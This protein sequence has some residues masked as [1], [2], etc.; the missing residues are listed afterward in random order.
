MGSETVSTVTFAPSGLA[1]NR[2]CSRPLRASSEPSVAMSMCLYICPSPIGIAPA[3]L[4]DTDPKTSD[5]PSRGD[6]TLMQRTE[7]LA[8]ETI[9]AELV[10]RPKP[11][12][13][14]NRDPQRGSGSIAYD[15]ST[16]GHRGHDGEN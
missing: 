11:R 12:P 2:P 1:R 7:Q 5:W 16:L 8:K 15:G 13:G 3:I 14:A 4:H 10:R 9:L 6:S